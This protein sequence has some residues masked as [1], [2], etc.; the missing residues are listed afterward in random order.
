MQKGR[1]IASDEWKD[2]QQRE[3]EVARKQTLHQAFSLKNSQLLTNI[4]I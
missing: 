4:H 3:I 1:K 2:P